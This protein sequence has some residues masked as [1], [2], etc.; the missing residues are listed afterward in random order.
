[1]EREKSTM[2]SD[3]FVFVQHAVPKAYGTWLRKQNPKVMKTSYKV[4]E[5]WTEIFF[6]KNS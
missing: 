1:M 3:N 2:V 6:E 5:V 4:W